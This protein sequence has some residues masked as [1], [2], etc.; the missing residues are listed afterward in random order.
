MNTVGNGLSASSLD[1][2]FINEGNWIRD[3]PSLSAALTDFV[4]LVSSISNG[5]TSA[6][7]NSYTISEFVLSFVPPLKIL[8]LITKEIYIIY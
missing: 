8:N 7:L 5:G 4:K 3:E 1:P 2:L 6:S